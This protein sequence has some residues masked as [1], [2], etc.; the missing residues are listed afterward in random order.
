MSVDSGMSNSKFRQHFIPQQFSNI[1]HLN[2]DFNSSG[3]K[4]S[5]LNWQSVKQNAGLI[6]AKVCI[7]FFINLIFHT[8]LSAIL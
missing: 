6:T 7:L 8:S 4:S 5:G 2:I 3:M 1:S